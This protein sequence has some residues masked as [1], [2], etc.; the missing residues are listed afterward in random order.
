MT[1]IIADFLKVSST[2]NAGADAEVQP[3][4]P[5]KYLSLV[6][7]KRGKKYVVT[8]KMLR[9]IMNEFGQVQEIIMGTGARKTAIVEF[10]HAQ[11]AAKAKEALHAKPCAIAGGK[12]FFIEFAVLRK[13]FEVCDSELEFGMIGIQLLQLL[14]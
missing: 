1:K 5:T 12:T 7:S 13:Q 9:E 11:D 2:A 6:W 10:E 14:A 3:N 8:E 4:V